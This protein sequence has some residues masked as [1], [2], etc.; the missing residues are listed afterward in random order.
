MRLLDA[1]PLISLKVAAGKPPSSSVS[2]AID[3]GV[4]RPPTL[5]LPEAR[6]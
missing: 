2:T 1:P 3:P 6:R 5:L 4:K